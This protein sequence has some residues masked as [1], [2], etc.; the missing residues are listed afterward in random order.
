MLKI[1]PKQMARRAVAAAFANFAHR[2]PDYTATL[3]D[4][5]FVQFHVTPLL[6]ARGGAAR[7]TA[8][9]LAQAWAAQLGGYPVEIELR[10]AAALPAAATFLELLADELAPH[11]GAIPTLRQL[12][13]A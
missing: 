7:L 2:H 6:V 3:F 10:S 12:A 13:A 9:H 8:E 1:S 11:G 4:E 5:V